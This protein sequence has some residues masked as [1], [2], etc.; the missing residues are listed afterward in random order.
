MFSRSQS[1]LEFPWNVS[2]KPTASAAELV[3]PS[4]D[5]D[6]SSS[7]VQLWFS[8]YTRVHLDRTLRSL[9]FS[10]G[11]SFSV[12]ES[13]LQRFPTFWWTFLY[14]STHLGR[15]RKLESILWDWSVVIYFRMKWKPTSPEES[16]SSH[17]LVLIAATNVSLFFFFFAKIYC[18]ISLYQVPILIFRILIIVFSARAFRS[19]LKIR[20]VRK[21]EEKKQQ[22]KKSKTIELLFLKKTI[23]EKSSSATRCMSLALIGPR[24]TAGERSGRT[25]GRF[26]CFSCE[27]SRLVVNALLHIWGIHSLVRNFPKMKQI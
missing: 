22:Q 3:F 2:L 20:A 17:V 26:V 6:V 10:S 15:C 8:K 1:G 4:Y 27:D 19:L 24:F 13:S 14:M 21:E 18:G 7:L 11:P 23:K 5:R 12:G 25:A 16:M 9:K